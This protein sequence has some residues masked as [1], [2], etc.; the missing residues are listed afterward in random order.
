MKCMTERLNRSTIAPTCMNSYNPYTLDL[1][2]RLISRKCNDLDFMEMEKVKWSVPQ[3]VYVQSVQIMDDNPVRKVMGARVDTENVRAKFDLFY[4]TNFASLVTDSLQK[5]FIKN[6]D[7]QIS[8]LQDEHLV[9]VQK[10]DIILQP[11][12]TKILNLYLKKYIDPQVIN[13][14]IKIHGQM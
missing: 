6:I 14:V 9:Y 1:V 8:K 2:I 7:K 13:D 12:V 5:T 10:I 4:G 11:D 3:Y